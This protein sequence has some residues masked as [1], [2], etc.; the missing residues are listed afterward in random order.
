MSARTDYFGRTLTS[1]YPTRETRITLLEDEDHTTTHNAL[2]WCRLST[3][4]L[5]P[6]TNVSPSS[7]QNNLCKD[8]SFMSGLPHDVHTPCAGY[9]KTEIT[10]DWL[11]NKKMELQQ[12][13]IE[14]DNDNVFVC[15]SAN[16]KLKIN[17]QV[18]KHT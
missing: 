7:P 9:I 18:E 12:F 6:H 1:G 17:V 16:K 5:W 8:R 15:W 10:T 3:D 4:A 14:Y 13:S 2:P 11:V